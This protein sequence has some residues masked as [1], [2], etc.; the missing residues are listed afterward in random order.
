MKSLHDKSDELLLALY[1][2]G[3]NDAFDVLFDRYQNQVYA[4]IFRAVKNAELADDIFQETF[5]KVILR[6]RERRYVESGKFSAWITRIAHNLVIDH[7][8]REKNENL[9]S[10]DSTDIDILNRKELCDSTIEDSMI[11]AQTESD[12][13]QLIEALPDNQRQVLTMR[14]YK[15]MSFKEIA[16]VTKVSINTALGRMR[17]A[18]LNMRRMAAEKNLVLSM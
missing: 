6:L 14:Y 3:C 10:A 7:F 17:Y 4:Y 13:R 1:V 8:R 16:E 18:I 11:V 12:I 15:N 2:D 9:Q 5:V